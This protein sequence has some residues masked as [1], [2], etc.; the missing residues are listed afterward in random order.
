[1]RIRESEN[2]GEGVTIRMGVGSREGAQGH[3]AGA[4][5]TVQGCVSA[6]HLCGLPAHLSFT[7]ISVP[8]HHEGRGGR[9]CY[10]QLPAF[11]PRLLPLMQMQKLDLLCIFQPVSPSKACK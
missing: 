10:Q 2:K 1:M 3:R 4:R 11:P 8:H 7:V 9:S 5:D 6:T